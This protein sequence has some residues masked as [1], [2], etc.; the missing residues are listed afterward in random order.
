MKTF[1]DYLVYI[2]ESDA[3][4]STTASS[5]GNTSAHMGKKE[6]KG[7]KEVSDIKKQPKPE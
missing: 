7:D 5:A 2:G 1:L 4:G 3:A 6:K